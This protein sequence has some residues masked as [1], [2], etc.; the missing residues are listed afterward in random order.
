MRLW[1]LHPGYLDAKGLVACWREGLLA[2]KVLQ[3]GT[4][5]YQHH[6]QLE[7]FRESVDPVELIDAYLIAVYEEAHKRGY[8]FERGKIGLGNSDRKIAVTDGQLR[9]EV[10]HLKKK[11]GKRDRERYAEI[12]N[13]RDPEPHP[14]F[15]VVSGGIETW[16]RPSPESPP[17][18]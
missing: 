14:L 17:Q 15:H 18:V 7:R 4:K 2:R 6:P 10:S 3:G 5:G 11:L 1:S 13:L 8:K 16:E 9:Y 12:V